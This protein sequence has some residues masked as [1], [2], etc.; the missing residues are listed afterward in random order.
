MILL[1]CHD[2]VNTSLQ[3]WWCVWSDASTASYQ[4]TPWTGKTHMDGVRNFVL[5]F[6]HV[7]V[8][9][10]SQNWCPHRVWHEWEIVVTLWQCSVFLSS[11]GAIIFPPSLCGASRECPGWKLYENLKP[12]P[13]PVC[14][15]IY[16]LSCVQMRPSIQTRFW[17]VRSTYL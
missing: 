17:K 13:C 14:L 9:T 15:S 7:N 8:K 1:W 6:S 5:M 12:K 10:R 2:D 11:E 4:V 3:L 16:A